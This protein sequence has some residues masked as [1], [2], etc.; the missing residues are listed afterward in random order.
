MG[1]KIKVASGLFYM[2][3]F[4]C[5][6]NNLANHNLT[7]EKQN[8]QVVSELTSLGIEAI[9]SEKGVIIYL[10]PEI[11]FD[12][13]KSDIKLEARSKISEISRELNKGYLADRDIEVAGHTNSNG[14]ADLNVEISRKRAQAA[15]EELVFSNVLLSRIKTT[16]HGETMPRLP[17]FDADG[18][19]IQEN[20]DLNRRVEFIVLNPDKN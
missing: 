9:E 2:L 14:D 19:K 10:P 16:W 12:E 17:E 18:N 1:I 15:T 7:V 6:S 3:L 4:G 11:N 20:L 5:A 8:S 13:S